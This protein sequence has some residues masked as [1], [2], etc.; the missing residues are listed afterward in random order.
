MPNDLATLNGKL[1]TA[2]RDTT[3]ATWATGEMD[4]LLE[5]AVDS[6]F[7][8]YMRPLDPET[9]TVTVVADDYYYSL[10]AG[11]RLVDRV[12][13]YDSGGVDHGAVSGRHWELVGDVM[14]GTGKL[15]IG[16]IASAGDVLHLQGYGLY[17]TSSNPVPDILIELVLARARSEAYRRVLADRERFK[18]WLARNQNQNVSLNEMLQLS[19]DA[20]AD[21]DKHARMAPRTWQRP[22][23]GRV[24]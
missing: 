17:D 8:R 20:D 13:R 18:A 10:P 19:R 15:H 11:V 24:G 7:P 2:L 23:S 22:V 14:S 21:A 5:R 9:T 4:E 1:A 12:D 3:Y 16:A 6:L